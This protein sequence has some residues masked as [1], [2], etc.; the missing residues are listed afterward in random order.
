MNPIVLIPARMA[1]TRLPGKPLADI[2]GRP[3]IAHVLARAM[4]AGIG[5]VAVATDAPEIVA[6]V[7]EGRKPLPG[8]GLEDS[9]HMPPGAGDPPPQEEA[10]Q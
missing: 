8:R 5:P 2:C 6:A 7:R 1:S 4:A 3:M 9:D 10:P